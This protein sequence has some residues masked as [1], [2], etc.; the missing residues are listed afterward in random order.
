GLDFSGTGSDPAG[1]LPLTFAWD[2]GGGAASQTVQSP[3]VVVFNSPG[4]YTAT[5][6][7]T[8]SVGVSDPT[9]ATR[10]ITVTTSL[11]NDE[12]HW[13]F[14]GPASVT[15]DWRGPDP[16]IFYGLTSAYGSSVDAAAASPTPFSSQGPFWEARLTDLQPD[17]LY[18]YAIASGP[19]H[20][21]RTP[22]ARGSSGFTVS[23][24]ADIS[25]STTSEN[26]G[27]I[28]SL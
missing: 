26:M 12:I 2:F 9:P 23:A 14:T 6:T 4:T 1:N 27:P 11:L 24:E 8:N 21:F 16:T 28:Q 19:D 13:T 10:V 25:D 18:H 3:G 7:V 5:L 22:P 20:T 17:A 15:F